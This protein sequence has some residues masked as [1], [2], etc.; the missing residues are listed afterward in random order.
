MNGYLISDTRKVTTHRLIEMKRKGEKISMLTSYDFTT[1]GI[2]DKAG[3]DVILVGDSASNVMAGNTTTLPMTVDQM[4]YHA[5]SVVR[6]VNRALVVCDMP[7]GSYQ[8]G[9]TDGVK[10]A[11]RI[12]KESGCDALKLE[13]GVEILDTVRRILDAGIPVMA[14]LGLTP[15]SINKFGTYAVR[16]KDEAEAEKLISDAKALDEAGCFGLVLEKVPAIL[17]TKVTKEISIPTIGIGAGNGTDGQVLVVADMLGMTQ[18]FSPR[19]LRRYANLNSI[20]TE[21][22]GHYIE[23]V[24]NGDFPNEKEAYRIYIEEKTPRDTLNSKSFRRKTKLRKIAWDIIGDHMLNS[25]KAENERVYIKFSPLVNPLYMSY[26]GSRGLSYK[27]NMGARY[28]FSA[29]SNITLSP[30]M[31]YNFKIK[32]WYFNI[33]MRY[34]YNKK[35]DA[36]TELTWKT[37]NRITNSSVLDILKNETRDTI[38]FSS[39]DLD[40]FDDHMLQLKSN[41]SLFKHF[42]VSV[43]C[44]YHQRNAVNKKILELIG[45]PSVYKSFAP[46]VTLGFVPYKSG[47][48]FT[49][50]YERSIP[51][52]LGSDT[53]Y[54]KWEFDLSFKKKLNLLSKYSFRVG[55]GF[56]TNKSTDY[57]VDFSNFRE[58]YIPGGW[59]DDWSGNFQLLNSQWYNASKYYIRTNFSYESPLLLLTW[60]PVVGRYIETERI[61]VSVL[62]IEYTKPYF[63]IG[64]GFTT[65]YLSIGA[66]GSFLEGKP[67]EFGC[68][69]TFELFRK[70]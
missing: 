67:K 52:V 27:I 49:A 66:F 24:K 2:V 12:M 58:N 5:R 21:A 45:K 29:N 55:G 70:W 36:W 34:T 43:G 35:H 54:E 13:G 16:A 64:Y 26:S 68:K 25:I 39:L 41:I 28:N 31:G 10:N 48:I 17:A 61:Y 57:F 53:K 4:I 22:I 56:Y 47:P 37:G 40:Y 20:M 51:N 9:D 3:M 59:D 42:N 62:Q 69:F 32:Q 6:G 18:G 23:D 8:T 33:P 65:R 1:A 60:M 14:H 44:V 15:Q 11:I 63:E 7:F 38:D 46:Q 19:F 50:N 30:H